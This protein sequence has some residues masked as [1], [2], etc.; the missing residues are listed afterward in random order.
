MLTVVIEAQGKAYTGSGLSAFTGGMRIGQ[1]SVAVGAND[2][3]AVNMHV[4]PA[5]AGDNGCGYV[6]LDAPDGLPFDNKRYFT[7]SALHA[8]SVLLVGDS[9]QTLPVAAALRSIENASW[10]PVI[11]RRAQAVTYADIDSA[12]LIILQTGSVVPQPLHLLLQGATFKNKAVLA[13][14]GLEATPGAS[15]TEGLGQHI[16]PSYVHS[17]KPLSPV[18]FDTVSLLWKDFP[19]LRE[20]DAAC[21]DYIEN[22]PGIPLAGLNNGKPMIT[23]AVDIHGN[24]RILC[25]V[26]L[27]IS[28][29][30]NLYQTGMYVPML[31]RLCRYALAAAGT[32]VTEWIA[33]EPHANPLFGT[34]REASI[35]NEHNELC[36]V[37]GSQPF[38]IV[39]APGLYL[40]HETGVLPYWIAV[41]G[42]NAESN[43]VYSLPVLPA[44]RSTTGS[45]VDGHT[46]VRNLV[47][48]HSMHYAYILWL[49]IALALAA[50]IAL[51]ERI[52]Q[53]KTI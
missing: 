1:A 19:Q 40:V 28:A 22:I 37:W 31:D 36:G 25:S 34:G 4:R 27:G 46:F 16:S 23:H 26:P 14:P 44:F 43:L 5:V 29:S 53:K 41:N 6:E 12:G 50:E 17:D 49:L 30:S 11:T 38:V 45:V 7:R 48:R 39:D 8:H 3:Q 10:S 24:A 42:N 9:A 52:P 2:T 47:Q 32:S 51:W 21:Y 13:A 35:T 33:G 15:F 20:I 18:L